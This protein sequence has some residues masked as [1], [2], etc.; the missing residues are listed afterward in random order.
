MAQLLLSP[1][2]L[3]LGYTLAAVLVA[4]MVRDIDREVRD[5]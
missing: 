2:P 3:I 4:F 5:A 1:W